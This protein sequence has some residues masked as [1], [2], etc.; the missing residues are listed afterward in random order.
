MAPVRQTDVGVTPQTVDDP[1]LI[2]LL[3]ALKSV[4]L[5]DESG[6]V[7][8][9]EVDRL[10][11]VAEKHQLWSSEEQVGTAGSTTRDCILSG[12]FED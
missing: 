3:V 1:A 7:V 8:D 2:A 12:R 10:V 6:T 4:Q 5:R 9:R 11:S